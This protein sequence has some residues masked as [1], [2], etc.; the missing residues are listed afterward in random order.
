MRIFT[1][2]WVSAP[3]H[4]KD[5]V[6][7]ETGI[8]LYGLCEDGTKQKKIIKGFSFRFWVMLRSSSDMQDLSGI[9]KNVRNISICEDSAFGSVEIERFHGKRQVFARLTSKCATCLH[10][11]YSTLRRTRWNA[12]ATIETF[13]GSMSPT[14]RLLQVLQMSPHAW[15]EVPMS[16]IIQHTD[17]FKS[18]DRATPRAL[19]VAAFDIE[20]LSDD[21]ASFPDA[22]KPLDTMEQI[23]LI[24][25]YPF[26]D[27]E[28]ASYMFTLK[29]V[30]SPGMIVVRCE[31]ERQMWEEFKAVVDSNVHVLTSYNGFAFDYPYMITRC[32]V[33]EGD[34]FRKTFSTAA[35]GCQSF[36]YV[37]FDGVAQIDMLVHLRKEKKLES[38]KLDN[39]AE[40]FLGM[41]KHDITPRQIF[42]FLK[43]GS[44]DDRRRIAEYCIQDCMLVIRLIHKFQV[45][46]ST[47]AMCQVTACPIKKI[48]VTGQQARTLDLLSQRLYEQ[49][50]L[51]PDRPFHVAEPAE[52][53][54]T[55]A[56][57]LEAKSG[58]YTDPVAGLD[59]AS[60]YPSIMIAKNLCVS[61]RHPGVPEDA[62]AFHNVDGVYYR[63]EP[64]GIFPKVLEYLWK[65]RKATR[66][67][68]KG[69]TDEDTIN[70]LNARQ[71]SY[72]LVMNS[73][74]G[75]LGSR[76]FPIE[77]QS[78]AKGVTWFGRQLLC[79]TQE[80]IVAKYRDKC[81]IVYGD[82]VT[83][84]TPVAT[85]HGPVAIAELAGRWQRYRHIDPVQQRMGRARRKQIAYP[86]HAVHVQTSSGLQELQH[87]VRRHHKGLMY[88][89]RL[90]DGTSMR[91]TGDHAVWHNHAWMAAK[92]LRVGMVL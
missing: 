79:D 68:M 84:D 70:T 1:L 8:L 23:G 71:L 76:F 12:E 20:C 88:M 30:T 86:P 22:E 16:E 58:L 9:L 46:E 34:V 67:L 47:F 65:T 21:C 51:L 4:R 43:H 38:Y 92:D 44:S 81:E 17:I 53:T 35:F 15:V 45:L 3:D 24:L 85:E 90:S 78:I 52:D 19:C 60:L 48:V 89:V 54:Y 72:K 39:V 82:S 87:L 66:D 33:Q 91:M 28:E 75:T 31:T 18:A 77:S 7:G 26:S 62:S 40:Q 57:V 27:R 10:M 42:G 59:F 83:G 61:T 13:E 2:D 55:G 11:A 74:Y 6:C 32:G 14:T 69:E 29:E 73:I 64:M 49:R 36:T 56:T 50:I 63:K 80:M 37:E 5:G 25:S 41:K